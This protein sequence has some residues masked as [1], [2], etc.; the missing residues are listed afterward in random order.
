[1]NR[2]LIAAFSTGWLLPIWIST[3]MLF[4]FLEAE[5]WPHL[6]GKHPVNCCPYVQCSCQAFAMSLLWLA[7]VIFFWAWRLTDLKKPMSSEMGAR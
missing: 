1:M 6:Q 5:V 7:A 2:L 3:W 4:G